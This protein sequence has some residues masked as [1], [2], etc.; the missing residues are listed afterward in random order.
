MSTLKR[1]GAVK[2]PYVKPFEYS[3]NTTMDPTIVNQRIFNN[4][5]NVMRQARG[6]NSNNAKAMANAHYAAQMANAGPSYTTRGNNYNFN[7]PHVGNQTYGTHTAVSLGG[8]TNLST[9]KQSNGTVYA[10]TSTMHFPSGVRGRQSAVR[11]RTSSTP[12][13]VG[14][15]RK[16][17]RKHKK[18]S[19][20]KSK[21]RKLRKSRK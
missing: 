2:K 18:E 12:K 19:R 13:S 17:T 3:A 10:N 5:T 1:S 11:G 8:P 16:K 6:L 20:T 7:D 14:G 9:M 4:P 15:A 21:S